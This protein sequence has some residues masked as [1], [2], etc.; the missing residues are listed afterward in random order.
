MASDSPTLRRREL[1]ARLRKLRLE[2]GKSIEEIAERLLCHPTKISRMETAK[3]A[4]SLRDVRDL[5]GIYEVDA[6]ERDELMR[7]ARDAR[8]QGWWQH[9]GDLGI[10][11]LIGLQ[12]AASSITDYESCIVPSLL[13]TEEYARA[14]IRGLAPRMRQEVLEERL[15]ARMRRQEILYKEEPPHFWALL[16]EAVLRRHVGGRD[17]MKRQ[18]DKIVAVGH[19][20]N[21]TIQAIPFQVG[22]HPGLDSTFV[23]MSFDDPGLSP[24]VFVEGLVGNIYLEREVDINRYREAVEHLRAAALGP[25]E[26]LDFISRLSIQL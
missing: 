20:S 15:E 26:S 16:D 7:L 21:V 17:L 24:V 12:D 10:A 5:C 18:L 9:Y 19:Q 4:A 2:S 25:A 8:Q 1:A 23:F 3:R 14:I 22:A 13:Q 11:P 6:R